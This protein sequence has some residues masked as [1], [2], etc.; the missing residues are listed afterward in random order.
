MIVIIGPDGCGKTTIAELIVKESSDYN[1]VKS[2]NFGI[3]PQIKYF[4]RQIYSLI[5]K[6][7]INKYE[8][9]EGEFHAGMKHAPNSIV[10]EVLLFFWYLMDYL[11]GHFSKS[12][13]STVFTRYYYDYFYQR[14]H[15]N[16]PSWLAKGFISLIPKP[17]YVFFLE[18][19]AEDIYKRKPELSLDEIKR[20]NEAI[21]SS[22]KVDGLI[23]V[24]AR[25]GIQST[26]ETIKNILE[27]SK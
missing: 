9:A 26:Y 22:V 5:G 13:N 2:K 8:H 16:L 24:N 19:D 4:K 15:F 11:L 10:K 25:N 27:G 23:V 20:Q 6:N 18:Q 12:K 21:I 17:D 3:L 7:Y 14:Q 1:L